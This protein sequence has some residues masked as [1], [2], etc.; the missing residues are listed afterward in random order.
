MTIIAPLTETMLQPNVSSITSSKTITTMATSTTTIS[1]A[2]ATNL[3]PHPLPP[4]RIVVIGYYG[5][6]NIGDDQY[7]DTIQYVIENGL[8]KSKRKYSIIFVDCDKLK[9][10]KIADSDVII[11]G[12]GDILNHYFLD[13]INAKFKEKPNKII[14]FSVGMPYLDILI[15]TDKLE[16]I[17][18]IFLRTRQ[19]CDILRRFYSPDRVFYLPDVSFFMKNMQLPPNR[20]EEKRLYSMSLSVITACH[21]TPFQHVKLKLQKWKRDGFKIAVFSLNRHIYSPPLIHQYVSIVDEFAFIVKWFLYKGYT[22]CFLPF[23]T[24]PVKGSVRA[25]TENDVLF[26]NDIYKYLIRDLPDKY[27]N[28]MLNIQTRFTATEIFELYDYFYVSVPMRFHAT[29]FSLYKTVPFVPVFTT[30]KTR[31]LLLDIQYNPEYTYELPVDENDIP[32]EMNSTILKEKINAVLSNRSIVKTEM[33]KSTTYFGNIIGKNISVFTDMLSEAANSTTSAKLTSM[34]LKEHKNTVI[35]NLLAKLN[36]YCDGANFQT[37]TDPHKRNIIVKIISFYLTG[38]NTKTRYNHGL[39]EKIFHKGDMYDY[40]TEWEWIIKDHLLNQMT[41]TSIK[42]ETPTETI[43]PCP[44]PLF[45]TNN[46][47]PSFNIHYMNQEDTSGV[48]RSGWKYVFDALKPHHDE[49]GIL[50]DLYIDRTF[51]W[52]KDILNVLGIIPYRKKWSGFLHHTFDETFSEYN[53]HRLLKTPEFVDS[54]KYCDCIYVLSDTLGTQLKEEL[55]KLRIFN[56]AVKTVCHPTEMENIPL[57]NYLAS[58]ENPDKRVLHVG[59]WLR[60]ILTFYQL[61]M[62]PAISLVSHARTKR[63]L[64]I[65]GMSQPSTFSLKKA[66]LRNSNGDNYFPPFDFK[67]KMA[68]FL[69]MVG[70]GGGPTD[71]GGC[72]SF[73]SHHCGNNG[74][75]NGQTDIIPNN[76]CRHFK[77]Y[78]NILFHEIDTIDKL[79]NAE[80]D[81]ILTN[82]I[83]FIHLIDASAVNTII[84][85]IVRNTPIIVNRHPAV[86][87]LLGDKYP[88]YYSDA[89]NFFKINMEIHTILMNP[90]AILHTHEYLKKMDKARFSIGKFKEDIFGGLAVDSVVL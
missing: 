9:E 42:L 37:I 26:H 68:D 25:N 81:K 6:H 87:E 39:M 36:D 50:L 77:E 48:H 64:E 49:N 19:D 34:K 52:E 76:W 10:C 69:K 58:V 55:A 28:H 51:H 56:V 30:K 21:L 46:S 3:R 63:G 85:C 8:Q 23:N 14:T 1:T 24:S 4:I 88:L 29:L 82:N 73:I 67:E 53:N 31:N 17:D 20:A 40:F 45:A 32:Y 80:Y 18:C 15:N 62:P 71:E 57:F 61:R 65:M 38:G 79:T 90:S 44:I 27:L 86:V 11:I 13:N 16:I 41:A 12:G 83:L 74:N 43:T 72:Q 66:V 7:I 78:I 59:G 70:G 22:V 60:N 2:T 75:D 84:E 54:L 35:Q 47:P 89:G 33:R 5:H